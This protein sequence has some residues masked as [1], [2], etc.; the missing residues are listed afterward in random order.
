[1]AEVYDQERDRI[2]ALKARAEREAAALIT[3]T[4]LWRL[5]AYVPAELMVSAF[6]AAWLAGA[7]CAMRDTE[8]MLRS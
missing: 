3:E 6:A 8:E 5:T 4:E 7:T 2:D 1:M